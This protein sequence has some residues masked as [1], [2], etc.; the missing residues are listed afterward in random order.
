MTAKRNI[1]AHP[2]VQLLTPLYNEEKSFDGYVEAVE[3]VLISRRDVEYRCLLVDDGSTDKTWELIQRQCDASP[4]FRGLRLSRN[5]GAHTAETA[6]LDLCDADAVVILSADLQ[7]PPE[8][9]PSFV[10]AWQQ[11]A[12]VVFGRRRMRQID[13]VGGLEIDLEPVNRI[14]QLLGGIVAAVG[15]GGDCEC[16]GKCQHGGKQDRSAKLSS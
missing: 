2:T 12:D 3:R 15:T 14:R 11:G 5:F 13:D 9:V 4:R 16:G 7:D 1:T 6:G 10:K 8:I